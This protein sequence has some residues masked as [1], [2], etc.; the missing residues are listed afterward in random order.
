MI[1]KEKIQKDSILRPCWHLLYSCILFTDC[2]LDLPFNKDKE[3]LQELYK[4][5]EE[6]FKDME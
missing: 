3:K 2:C 5:T 1:E 4:K 6:V